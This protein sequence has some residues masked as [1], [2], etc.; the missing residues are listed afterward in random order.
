MAWKTLV[1]ETYN[2][3][4]VTEDGHV[5]KIASGINSDTLLNNRPEK[6]KLIVDD[7][8][9]ILPY[10]NIQLPSWFYGELDEALYPIFNAYHLNISYN[11]NSGEFQA[12]SD[13]VSVGE[14]RVQIFIESGS[15]KNSTTL[16]VKEAMQH[17]IKSIDESLTPATTIKKLTKQMLDPTGEVEAIQK[18]RTI[19]DIWEQSAIAHG[20][21]PDDGET[22]EGTEGG[23]VG[24]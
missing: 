9:E 2:W 16:G 19:A 5:F 8:E 24:K 15:T 3:S 23:N 21:K 10:Y 13:S 22:E 12:A 7:Y 20:Y 4:E 18:A 6:I 11:P 14:H 17:F 1:D